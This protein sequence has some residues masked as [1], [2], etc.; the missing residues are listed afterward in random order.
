MKRIRVRNMLAGGLAAAALFSFGCREKTA[1][2][3]A[4]PPLV[5]VVPATEGYMFESVS[6]IA[7]VKAYEEVN[8]VARVEGFLVKRLFGEGD[9]VKKGQLLYEIEPEIYEAKV[10]VAE[11]ELDKARASQQNAT[12]EY[13]RQKTLVGQEATSKRKFDEA[14]AAKLEADAAVE[15]A[16]A[17]LA[18]AKQN[19]SYTKIFSPFD[20]QIGFNT[21]SMGNLVSQSSGTLATVVTVDPMRVEFVI[22]ELD[23]LQL[24]RMRTGSEKPKVRVRLFLQD[25]VEYEE[26]GKI[27]YWSNRV[28]PRTG[29]FLL[30]ALFPNKKWQLMAGMFVRV[31]IGPDE[32]NKS[33]LIPQTALM[34]DLAGD[35]V[36]VV[37]K[38][39]KV[40]RRDLELGYRDRVNVVVESGLKPGEAVIV[41]GVQKVRPGGL[42]A[43]E[44]DSAALAKIPL[45]AEAALA[46]EKPASAPP[47]PAEVAAVAKPVSAAPDYSIPKG[48]AGAA[49]GDGK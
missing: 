23:L 16:T 8:L 1:P 46:R 2:A 14:T 25:G 15:E 35:Y 11:A 18:L 37:G 10:H 41:E 12:S 42:A 33:V 24:L 45:T 17:N 49:D 21:Y 13:E 47:Y 43:P 30:Q 44:V 9:A 26:E 3:G 29:T 34:A 28:D 36:Y 39:G 38:D 40:E 6:A 20:G 31:N 48:N 27:A 7:S 32:P 19:L 4:K 5:K 22:N